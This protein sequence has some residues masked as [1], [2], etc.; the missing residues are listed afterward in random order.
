MRNFKANF[1]SPLGFW[2]IFAGSRVLLPRPYSTWKR[3]LMTSLLT[4]NDASGRRRC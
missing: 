4:G 3:S 2:K 1:V